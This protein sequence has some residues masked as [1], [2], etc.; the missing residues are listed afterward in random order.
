MNSQK[1]WGQ[2]QGVRPGK[3]LHRLLDEGLSPEQAEAEF[4][5]LYQVQPEKAELLLE[6]VV[7]ERALF[8]GLSAD[9]LS[10]YVGIPFC[11]TRC[12]YCSFP[13]HSLRE[14]GR[15]R[16]DFVAALLQEIQQVGSLVQ[17]LGR[18]VDS[19]YIG[20]GTPTALAAPE[21]DAVLGALRATFPGEWQELTV[22]AGRPET[23]TPAHLKVMREHNVDRVS[24]NP[25]TKHDVTLEL[26]GRSHKAAQIAEA[27]A[28]CREVGFRTLNMDLILGL[29]GETLEMVEES[30]QWVLSFAPENITLHMFSPKRASRYTQAKEDYL[31]LLPDGGS[32]AAMSRVARQQ[33]AA[34]GYIPYYLYRQRNILGG[35]ENV[36][37]AL[38]GHECR[39]NILMIEERQDILGFGGGAG[40]KF[41]NADLSLTNYSNPKDALVY[42]DRL[43]EIIERKR[44]FILGQ[45]SEG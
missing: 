19:I 10:I 32:A 37:W 31:A 41:L 30:L 8:A 35:Q 38:P 39:Y 16:G 24:I 44:E 7:R 1:P 34:V 12:L 45:R 33:L 2:L 25:Q 40:S 11:P 43:P 20:G 9:A 23:I 21:L 13:A 18:P 4:R 6:I 28:A 29:P 27:V 42:I 17:Q 36:G 26:I 5:R 3:L 14:L 22:E 15:Y